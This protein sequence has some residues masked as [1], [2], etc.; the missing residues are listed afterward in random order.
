MEQLADVR[1]VEAAAWIAVAKERRLPV[2]DDAWQG[3]FVA[4]CLP[5]GFAGYAKL[6]HPIH[7]DL[8][9]ADRT[10][11]WAD[12]E[13]AA[14]GPPPG[15]DNDVLKEALIGTTLVHGSPDQPFPARRIRWRELA[16]RY[17]LPF[18][19]EI[20]TESFRRVF[21]RSWPRYLVGPDEGALDPETCQRVARVLEPFTDDQACFFYYDPLATLAAA[22]S[23]GGK[24]ER[25][26]FRGKLTEVLE[27]IRAAGGADSLSPTYWWPADHRWC[28]YSDYDLPFTLIGGPQSLIE[29]LVRD[30]E[31]ECVAVRASTR[32]DWQA[33][34]PKAGEGR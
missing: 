4:H 20:N 23:T 19:P 9:V 3:L 12:A 18:R 15:S 6:L 16:E 25:L 24:V 27:V 10:L 32:I 26:L 7:E 2:P 14:G 33:D 17:G 28:L 13:R 11:T 22:R 30:P 21:P 1:A 8:S 29:T 5:H 31:L 34:Q